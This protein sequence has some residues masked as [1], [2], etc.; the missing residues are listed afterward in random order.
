MLLNYWSPKQKSRS[1]G[2]IK[3]E[4]SGGAANLRPKI[5]VGL[6]LPRI[7]QLSSDYFLGAPGSMGMGGKEI[8][9]KSGDSI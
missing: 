1:R 2:E 3:G 8:L 4:S 6:P 7:D 9:N 5:S